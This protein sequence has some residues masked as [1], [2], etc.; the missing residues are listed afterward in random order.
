[1]ESAVKP[2]TASTLF[3]SNARPKLA[4]MRGET[5]ARH[6]VLRAEGFDIHVKLTGS[7]PPRNMDGQ[8]LARGTPV[9]VDRARLHLLRDGERLATTVADKLGEFQF[10]DVPEGLL[11]LQV[12]LPNLTV[13]GALSLDT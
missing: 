11:S 6:L 9:P 5:D 12:D 7:T 13:V 3:D 10:K 4:G 8:I 2:F 1:M